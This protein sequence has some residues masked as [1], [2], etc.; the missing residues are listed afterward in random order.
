M[1]GYHGYCF[2]A[3]ALVWPIVDSDISFNIY[4]SSINAYAQIMRSVGL[5][6]H[7]VHCW[8]HDW[9]NSSLSVLHGWRG[10]C[11]VLILREDFSEMKPIVDPWDNIVILD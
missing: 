7:H 10:G 6:I 1:H 4:D 8:K 3:S 5:Y 11:W 9:F 2:M